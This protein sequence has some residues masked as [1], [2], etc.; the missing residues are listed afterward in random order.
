M[1]VL[2]QEQI[3]L[4]RFI[5]ILQQEQAALVAADVD[6]LQSLS[7][8]K[9]Q[10]S[11]QLNTLSQQRAT[12][13]QRA[14]FTANA[15]GV[16]TWLATQPATVKDAWEKLLTSAQTAQRLNQT[17]GKLIQTH[18]QHNQQALIALMGAANRADVYGADGQPRT[19]PSTTQRSLGKG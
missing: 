2:Q 18:L 8:D 14:G 19:G 4:D 17:N 16:K 10:L 3:A 13:L 15:E 12:Q 9:Q 6:A 7:A 5:D 11:E 1:D